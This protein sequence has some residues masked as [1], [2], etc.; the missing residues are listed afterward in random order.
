MRPARIIALTLACCMLL[1]GCLMNIVPRQIKSGFSEE[2]VSM[3]ADKYQLTIPASAEFITGYFDQALQDPSVHIAFTVSATDLPLMLSDAW[4]DDSKS[5]STPS[6]SFFNDLIE[7][8][9]Q[10]YFTYTGEMFTYLFCS[11]PENGRI[12]CA[13]I[14][15]H[16]GNP[17]T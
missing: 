14:G 5:H 8:E 9:P 12:T 2:L 15:R 17:I 10:Q 7:M 6:D 4:M 11:A 3:L 1:S 16:P 13:F